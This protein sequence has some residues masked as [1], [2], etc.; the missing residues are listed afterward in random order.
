[1]SEAR[2][3]ARMT[4]PEYLVMERTSEVKHE[5]VNGEVY[6]MAGGTPEHGRL[7]VAFAAVL[8]N[9][10]TGKPC[11]LY[12]S[13]VRVRVEATG[14]STYPDL[15]VVCGRLERASDDP[16]AIANP[17]VIVGVL[18]EST[19]ASDRGDKFAHYRRLASL[20]E[21][22]LVSQSTPRIEVFHRADS[23]AWMLTE[24]AS[25]QHA[26]LE[27]LGISLAVDDV[28]YDPLAS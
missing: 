18:S 12:N 10:L 22:V 2:Q 27:S 20:R 25:G 9:A 7:A 15:S 13:D 3:T 23:G 11:V 16:D 26:T 17:S 21:Y 28:Y 5:Y 6:A 19:E 4:Y 14:R 8:R 24:A 1:M